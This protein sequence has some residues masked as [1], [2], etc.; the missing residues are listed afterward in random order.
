MQYE[1]EEKDEDLIQ[2]IR[3]KYLIKPSKEVYN[4]NN[5]KDDPSMGQAQAVR[6][7]T[8]DQV[9]KVCCLQISL[10]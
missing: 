7:I 1:Y 10:L 8:H 6:Q 4:L 9:K 5:F 2:F 3:S